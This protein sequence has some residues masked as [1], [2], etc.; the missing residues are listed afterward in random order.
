MRDH[1]SVFQEDQRGQINHAVLGFQ[2]AFLVNVKVFVILPSVAFWPEKSAS[3]S[4]DKPETRANALLHRVSEPWM[5]MDPPVHSRNMSEDQSM[6]CLFNRQSIIMDLNHWGHSV[7]GMD[8]VLTSEDKGLLATDFES[9]DLDLEKDLRIYE[10]AF[11]KRFINSWTDS[12]GDLGEGV[13]TGS[14]AIIDGG[15]AVGSSYASAA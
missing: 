8:P 3:K 9:L 6:T 1:L 2:V 7:A 15:A 14:K 4:N 10:A 11:G 5:D 12:Y 13:L